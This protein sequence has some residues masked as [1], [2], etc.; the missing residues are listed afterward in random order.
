MTTTVDIREAGTTMNTLRAITL[1]DM[2]GAPYIVAQCDAKGWNGFH[3][4][5]LS[6]G[7]LAAHFAALQRNDPNGTWDEV[8]FGTVDGDVV[9]WDPTNGRWPMAT[10]GPS[11]ALA[12][13]RGALRSMALCGPTP[14][15]SRATPSRSD[16]LTLCHVVVASLHDT[17]CPYQTDSNPTTEGKRHGYSRPAIRSPQPQRGSE[18]S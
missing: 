17:S 6:M 18:G 14:Q 10:A 8:R 5:L 16:P 4:P 1:S 11:S 13:T 12:S 3:V 7:E 2:E 9:M 15:M